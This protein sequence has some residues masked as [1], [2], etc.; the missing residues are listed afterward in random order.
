LTNT[1][2]VNVEFCVTY[3]N[4]DLKLEF[5]NNSDRKRQG[6]EIWVGKGHQQIIHVDFGRFPLVNVS[7]IYSIISFF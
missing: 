2:K 5:N 7:Y 1:V 3:I 4:L 6:I